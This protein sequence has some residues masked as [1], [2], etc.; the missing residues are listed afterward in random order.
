MAA[1]GHDAQ[2]PLWLPIHSQMQRIAISLGGALKPTGAGGG[3][4]TAP[5]GDATGD[6]RLRTDDLLTVLVEPEC[7]GSRPRQHQLPTAARHS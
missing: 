3:D 5:G 4:L 6:F 1:L 7:A 2:A